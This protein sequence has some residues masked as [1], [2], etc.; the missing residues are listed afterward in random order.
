MTVSDFGTICQ[1][2]DAQQTIVISSANATTFESEILNVTR[3][4]FNK[5]VHSRGD[6]TPPCGQPHDNV[7]LDE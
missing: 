5:I 3:R 6:K 4:S 2:N 7:L 1:R